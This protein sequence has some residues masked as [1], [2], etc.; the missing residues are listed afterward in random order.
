MWKWTMCFLSFPFYCFTIHCCCWHT[1]Q[2]KVISCARRS[3]FTPTRKNFEGNSTWSEQWCP[4]WNAI[5]LRITKNMWKRREAQTTFCKKFDHI[6]LKW[7]LLML[8]N[9]RLC[10]SCVSLELWAI[11]VNYWRNKLQRFGFSFAHF[12]VYINEVLHIVRIYW[13]NWNLS[14]LQ[15]NTN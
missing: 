15:L 2:R 6:S 13:I 11:I 12:I 7:S 3:V 1:K 10:F 5:N 14:S 9:S 4:K 8:W